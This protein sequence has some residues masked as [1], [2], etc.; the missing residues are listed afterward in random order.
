VCIKN[1]KA[2]EI[3]WIWWFEFFLRCL[4]SELP[5]KMCTK[6]RRLKFFRGPIEMIERDHYLMFNI[7]RVVCRP[8]DIYF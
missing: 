3:G 1:V 6:F 4:E 7:I 5:I 2:N 8:E